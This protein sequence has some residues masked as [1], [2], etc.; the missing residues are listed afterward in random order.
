MHIQG[1]GGSRLFLITTG[2]NIILIA[3]GVILGNA[4]Y[5]LITG[6]WKK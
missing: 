2:M 3:A 5:D 6:R 1:K 4:L